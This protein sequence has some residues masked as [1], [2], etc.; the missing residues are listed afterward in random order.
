[1]STPET[2]SYIAYGLRFSSPITLPFRAADS[3][4]S[5]DVVVRWGETP[6]ALGADAVHYGLWCAQPGQF[7]HSDPESGDIVVRDA[8]EI[9]VQKQDI[10]AARVFLTGS[11]LTALLQQRG[12]LTLHASSVVTPWGAVA[13]AGM[14][15]AGKSTLLVEMLR[16]GHMLVADD[17]TAVKIDVG[18]DAVATPGFPAARLWRETMSRLDIPLDGAMRRMAGIDKYVVPIPSFHTDPI[19]LR[20]LYLLNAA[21]VEHVTLHPLAPAEAFA[22]T[23]QVMH[24]RRI[25]RAMGQGPALFRMLSGLCAGLPVMRVERPVEGFALGALADAI[26]ADLRGSAP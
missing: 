22:Q 3:C 13:F 2:A 9:I 16:R 4:A 21:P 19:P 5:P 20:R 15:G 8:R 25:A 26:E 24:R 7:L 23:T 12:F 10:D 11:A 17:V 1:M 18:G 6:A 14:S